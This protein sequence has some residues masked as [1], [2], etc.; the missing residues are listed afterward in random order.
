[1]RNVELNRNVSNDKTITKNVEELRLV[2]TRK[3]IDLPVL[4]IVRHD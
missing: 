4:F 3:S 2:R 1:M